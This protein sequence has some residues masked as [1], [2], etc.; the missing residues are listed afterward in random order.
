VLWY[1]HALSDA[2]MS[3]KFFVQAACGSDARQ[4]KY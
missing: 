1:E 2:R 4:P 3:T